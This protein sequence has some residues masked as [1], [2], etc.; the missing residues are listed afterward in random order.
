MT[1]TVPGSHPVLL[2]DGTCGFCAESVQLVLR[3]D[4]RKTL[5]F[6]A[7]QGEFGAAVRAR[8]PAL[9]WVDSIIWVEPAG[10]GAPER[11]LVRS[12][13][14]LRVAAYLGGWFTLTRLGALVPRPIRDRAYD[15]IAR[16]RHRLVGAG[17]SCLVPSAEVR[18][19]FLDP[20]PPT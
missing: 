2:Y 13:A 1:A 6:A 12:D 11:V 20:G 3:H 19:R 7:L 5:R 4:R 10:A 14:A 17:P 16:H 8:H 9:E 15:L 18:G